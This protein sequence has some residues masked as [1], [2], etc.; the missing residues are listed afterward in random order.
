MSIL[1][2]QIVSHRAKK[3]VGHN[4]YHLILYDH[5]PIFHRSF[6]FFLFSLFIF[7]FSFFSFVLIFYTHSLASAQPFYWSFPLYK[8]RGGQFTTHIR[9]RKL[10]IRVCEIL[11]KKE[12]FYFA[13]SKKYLVRVTRACV[14]ILLEIHRKLF[15]NSFSIFFPKKSA[16]LFSFT[17]EILLFL[18]VFSKSPSFFRNRVLSKSLFHVFSPISH[19]LTRKTSTRTRFSLYKLTFY[20]FY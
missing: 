4:A 20:N 15:K 8:N 17:K 9:L 12:K 6:V 3:I 13:F 1:P 10:G 19:F 16:F 5:W 7:L 2:I 11:K 18:F 14:G